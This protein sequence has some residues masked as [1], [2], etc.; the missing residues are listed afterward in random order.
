MNGRMIFQEK[1]A[2]NKEA[3]ACEQTLFI[4]PPKERGRMKHGGNVWEGESP[5]RW[6]DFSAN[7]CPEGTPGWVM[8]TMKKAL[9]DTRYYP[10][11]AMKAARRGLAAYAGVDERQILPTAGGASAIDLVLSQARETVCVPRVTFG[12]YRERALV[13]GK[14]VEAWDGVKDASFVLCNPNNP[15]GQVRT[16]EEVLGL[17]AQIAAAGGELIVDEAFIDFCPEN[18]VRGDVQKGLSVVG[19]LTKTLCIPGVRLGYICAAPEKIEKLEQ[20]ALPWALG[21]L[22]SAVAANLPEHLDEMRESVAG[23]AARRARFAQALSALGTEVMP[24]GANFLLVDFKRNMTNA[25]ARLKEKQILVRTC[26]SFG[27]PESM[28]RLAVKRDEENQR[29]VQMLR[30]ILEEG[31]EG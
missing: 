23:N 2:C 19:S 7:L 28:W 20:R 22:A 3:S 14:R 11:R 17:Y 26:A 12:E 9:L 25:A 6:L 8:E 30:V 13:H 10:D 1:M 24:S 5:D 4:C 29:F 16:R 21:T 18:S 27:L 15:T 31:N